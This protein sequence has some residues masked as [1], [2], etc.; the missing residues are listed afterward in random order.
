VRDATAR[1]FATPDDR[2]GL[3]GAA[4]QVRLRFRVLDLFS[5]LTDARA[6]GLDRDLV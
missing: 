4:R 6:V 5:R 3:R 1:V 2:P